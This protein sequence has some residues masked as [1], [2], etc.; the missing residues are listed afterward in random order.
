MKIKPI[1]TIG[2][3]LEKRK[4]KKAQKRKHLE[5]L[6]QNQLKKNVTNYYEHGFNKVKFPILLVEGDLSEDNNN[7]EFYNYEFT[8]VWD[9]TEFAGTTWYLAPNM[10]SEFNLIDFKG[11]IWNFKYSDEIDVCIPGSLLKKLE[12][13]EFKSY[14][15]RCINWRDQDVVRD[16]ITKANSIS[17]IFEVIEKHYKSFL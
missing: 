7:F 8:V 9:L 2:S 6:W 3:Y 14:V 5:I 16:A 1:L 15:I 12:L 11:E 10:Q 4:Q 13:N 17:S